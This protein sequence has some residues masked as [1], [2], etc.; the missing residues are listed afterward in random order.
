MKDEPFFMNVPVEKAYTK[1]QGSD[2]DGYV[3]PEINFCH[4][5]L[6]SKKVSH[7]EEAEAA[8]KSVESDVW[9][10]VVVFV[11]TIQYDTDHGENEHDGFPVMMAMTDVCYPM[12]QE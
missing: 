7:K 2:S 1:K 12:H 4:Y 5:V 3:F 11:S 8:H 9:C 6:L 10:K